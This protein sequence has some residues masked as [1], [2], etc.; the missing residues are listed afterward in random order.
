MSN[1][2]LHHVD[3]LPASYFAAL[4][5]QAPGNRVFY[6]ANPEDRG[7]DQEI[8]GRILHA[9]RKITG[10]E[11]AGSAALD[12]E[13]RL[14]RFNEDYAQEKNIAA[15]WYFD[16]PA[17]A[18]GSCKTVQDALAACRRW[19]VGE[20]NYVRYD[21][22]H[23]ELFQRE[24]DRIVRIEPHAGEISPFEVADLAM[25]QG[26][27]WRIFQ[28][29]LVAGAGAPGMEHGTV[30]SNFLKE[31]HSLK[32]EIEERS[33]QYFDFQAL[34]YL[35]SSEATL[36]V[37]PVAFA[38]DSL[39][40]LSRE[41]ATLGNKFKINNSTHTPL[42]VF[43]ER[44]GIAY[45][46]SLFTVPDATALNA[47]D[48]AFRGRLAGLDCYLA[49][50]TAEALDTDGHDAAEAL[51]DVP[52]EEEEQ[53]EFLES[54]RRGQDEYLMSSRRRAEELPERLTRR[55][56]LT[57]GLEL[58]YYAGGTGP[59]VVVL[60]ALG[61]GLECW[62]RLLHQ[63]MDSH[64]VIIWEPRGTNAPPP[65]FGLADQL[66]DIEAILQNEA[67]ESCHLI[68]WC[69]GPK[70]AVLFYLAHPSA[71][72]SMVFLNTTL[73]CAG[74]P[75]DLDSPYE[76]NVESM[77][78]ALARKPAMAATVMKTFQE[79]SEPNEIETLKDPD[80]EQMS[81]TVLSQMNGKLREHVLAPFRTETT[82]V[83]YAHQLID[84]WNFDVRDKA[85]TVSVPVL[86]MDAEYDQVATPAASREA[87]K[88]FPAAR[89]VHVEG[90]THYCLY[91]RPEF[92]AGLLKQFFKHP[93]GITVEHEHDKASDR[94]SVVSPD[95]Q[96][97][98]AAAGSDAVFHTRGA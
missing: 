81:A 41:P 74:S 7:A 5:L 89:R 59:T 15:Y 2:I 35:A 58:A 69:T 29:S 76:K 61:Q 51:L 4:Y 49:A 82:T 23:L 22:I 94:R 6:R 48:R 40:R 97:T 77:C 57:R 24:Q 80:C 46:L 93:D 55:T 67:I 63:L 50:G 16:G 78:R 8:D 54:F 75:E 62:Y 65:P 10:E 68:G 1:I 43:C 79:R 33:P 17:L 25:T 13:N 86:L 36:N 39:L 91:D 73:K 42:S 88:L 3:C 83:N 98:S 84:F 85:G 72:R 60:N 53:I 28:I 66:S 92:V 45:G 34:R 19:G 37:V 87:A 32:A 44:V 26:L 71:V 27:Q 96:S 95:A 14:C 20:F 12:F 90:A 52:F 56:V 18:A 47:I 30:L 70:M 21:S 31:L 38:A 11:Q 9:S 64:C